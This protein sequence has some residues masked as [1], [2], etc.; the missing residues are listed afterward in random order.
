PPTLIQPPLKSLESGH[1]RET[2]PTRD[3]VTGGE[4]GHKRPDKE[5]VWRLLRHWLLFALLLIVA[6]V[7]ALLAVRRLRPPSLHRRR[8]PSDMTDLWQEAGRRLK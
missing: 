3:V 5:S 2:M 7:V 4:S 6:M 8:P 1:A